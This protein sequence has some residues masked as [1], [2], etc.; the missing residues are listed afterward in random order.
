MARIR[1]T[2]LVDLREAPARCK[3]CASRWVA[4]VART[5]PARLADYA[6]SSSNAVS[7]S[8]T[9]TGFVKYL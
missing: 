9:F 6:S 5:L 8:S 1:T 3:R 7:S 2:T 4:V